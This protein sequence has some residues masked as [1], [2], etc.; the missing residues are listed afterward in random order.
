M[1]NTSFLSGKKILVV[2]DE[3]DILVVLKELL[4]MCDVTTASSFDKAEDMLKSRDFDAAILDIMGVNG[5]GL[6]NIAK[7]KKIPA[8]MLT[9]HA[10]T[11]DNLVRSI[12]EGA[13]SYLPKETISE[14][15]DYLSDV[16]KARAE[17][18]DPWVSWQERLPT[19][20]FEKRWGAAWQ[21]ADKE[22]WERFKASIQGKKSQSQ[23]SVLEK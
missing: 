19:T 8:I 17:G 13:V 5:Y 20:Y 18:R 4:S 14:I 3:P 23:K 12:K 15:A 9:A 6:L 1:S 10:F 21:D 16:L 7:R 2:D 22:F 11:P